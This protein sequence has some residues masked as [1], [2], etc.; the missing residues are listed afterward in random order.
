MG[1]HAAIMHR[2][3]RAQTLPVRRVHLRHGEDAEVA[4]GEQQ[5]LPPQGGTVWMEK[6]LKYKIKIFLKKEQRV[7]PSGSHDKSRSN[8]LNANKDV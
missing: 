8:S 1:H 3:E 2:T 7:R 5:I 6:H 4:L